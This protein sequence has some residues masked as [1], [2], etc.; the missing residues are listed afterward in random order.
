[1]KTTQK[2]IRAFIIGDGET[3]KELQEKA[4]KM[5]IRFASIGD[6][7]DE[8][9][10]LIFTSWRSDI[11]TVNA[12]LDIIVL[13]SLNEGTPVSLIEA[14]AAN[15]PIVSTRV[16]GIADIVIENETAL[17]SD[18]GDTAGFQKNL[19]KLVED[20]PLRN[21]LGKKG[22]DHVQQKFRVERLVKDMKNLYQELLVK[23]K[24]TR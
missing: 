20:E 7:A 4:K 6:N 1:M 8:A 2:K 22:A 9:A 23:K 17:L 18:V 16:G 14:Q 21:C 15:K 5:G 24:R 3:K 12:G 10:S 11:D 19:L 13:T